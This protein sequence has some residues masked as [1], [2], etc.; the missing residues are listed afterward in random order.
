V[1]WVAVDLDDAVVNSTV[2]AALLEV[3][4]VCMPHNRVHPQSQRRLISRAM[5][6]NLHQIQVM[7]TLDEA[8]LMKS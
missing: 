8:F 1:H 5:N 6:Y 4:L 2:G 3:L 7:I